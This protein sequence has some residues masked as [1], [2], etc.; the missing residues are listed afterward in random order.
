[1]RYDGTYG[2]GSAWNDN[3]GHCPHPSFADLQATGGG[4]SARYARPGYQ[5]GMR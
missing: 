1:M 5:Q 2:T 4:V 3:V